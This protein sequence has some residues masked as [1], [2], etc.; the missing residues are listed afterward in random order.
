MSENFDNKNR[1]VDTKDE[2]SA[3]LIF[4]ISVPY[5]YS[6]FFNNS[7]LFPVSY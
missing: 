5:S 4:A 6:N 2:N 3:L 1:H 7:V